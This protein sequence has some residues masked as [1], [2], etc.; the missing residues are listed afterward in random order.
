[1]L[2]PDRVWVNPDCGLKTRKPEEV[3]PALEHMV[4]AAQEVRSS[5]TQ[6]GSV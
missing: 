3:W 1:V 4:E 6:S 2:Q 5:L